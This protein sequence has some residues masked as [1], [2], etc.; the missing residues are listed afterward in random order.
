[1]L[2]F[3]VTLNLLQ[4]PCHGAVAAFGILEDGAEWM[5]KRVQHDG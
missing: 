5:L 2:T 1:M 3:L 4:G